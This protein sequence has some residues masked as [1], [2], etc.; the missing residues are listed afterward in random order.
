MDTHFCSDSLHIIIFSPSFL[1][2]LF[3]HKLTLIHVFSHMHLLC[4]TNHFRSHF[5]AQK[6]YFIKQENVVLAFIN[7]YIAKQNST[8]YSMH[9]QAAF[10]YA[11]INTF[12]IVSQE[13]VSRKKGSKIN[14]RANLVE[15]ED[16]M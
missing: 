8:L 13:A 1:F 6:G 15:V 7:T 4:R 3:L 10:I 12:F 16:F 14:R 5:I 9:I 11:I 2:Y